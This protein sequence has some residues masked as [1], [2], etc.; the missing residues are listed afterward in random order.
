MVLV[1]LRLAV[2][3]DNPRASVGRIP[4]HMRQD[5]VS[6]SKAA[7]ASLSQQPTLR[8]YLT[9]PRRV[10]LEGV[11]AVPWRQHQRLMHILHRVVQE[12]RLPTVRAVRRRAVLCDVSAQD[13]LRLRLEEVAVVRRDLRGIRHRHYPVVQIEV[14][15]ALA[16]TRLLG[17][18]VLTCGST[19]YRMTPA[20][21]I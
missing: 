9:R 20:G 4:L 16:A 19:P 1:N 21:V 18:V 13:M 15:D 17:Q 10:S 6:H 11:S 8:S 7:N 3:V 5:N 14:L 2:S 12:E